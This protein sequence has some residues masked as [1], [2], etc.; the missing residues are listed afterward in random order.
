LKNAE[1]AE[2]I[3]DDVFNSDDIKKAIKLLKRN[4]APGYDYISEEFIKC[5]DNEKLVN[6]LKI[7]FNMIVKYGLKLQ[8]F[9][10]CLI[11]PIPKNNKTSVNLDES[12][13]ISVSTSFALIYE[14]LILSKID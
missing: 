7:L 13:P 14:Q 6:I 8:R 11:T 5:C 2:K 4:K 12:R 3:Y 10:I 9:N 1:L